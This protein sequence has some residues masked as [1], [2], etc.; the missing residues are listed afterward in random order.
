M[1]SLRSKLRKQTGN[2]AAPNG[3]ENGHAGRRRHRRRSRYVIT[4]A[5]AAQCTCPDFCE[6]DHDND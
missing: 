1:T 4:S 6:R 3:R 2:G 5:E